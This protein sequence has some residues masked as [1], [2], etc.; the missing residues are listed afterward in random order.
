[1][2]CWPPPAHTGCNSGAAQGALL[3][4]T[5]EISSMLDAEFSPAPACFPS[6]LLSQGLTVH[7]MPSCHSWFLPGSS[8]DSPHAPACANFPSNPSSH[9][10]CRGML[11]LW[12]CSG[13]HNSTLLI[14]NTG[15]FIT[16]SYGVANNSHIHHTLLIET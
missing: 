7:R 15:L 5:T 1:M 12:G 16:H 6:L 2:W 4:D 14:N 11:R 10:A 3:A 9:A 8:R 13:V